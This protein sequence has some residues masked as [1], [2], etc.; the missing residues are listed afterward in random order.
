[1]KII[2]PH[3]KDLSKNNTLKDKHFEIVRAMMCEKLIS[4][5]NN[6]ELTNDLIKEHLHLD[7]D[8]TSFY[9]NEKA[10]DCI[11]VTFKFNLFELF[12]CEFELPIY[13]YYNED[14]QQSHYSAQYK[15][16][17]LD[18]TLINYLNLNHF[19]KDPSQL[20]FHLQK[21]YYGSAYAIKQKNWVVLI[22]LRKFVS[23]TYF[24]DQDHKVFRKTFE[25]KHLGKSSGTS[26]SLNSN[27]DIDAEMMLLRFTKHIMNVKA[28][29]DSSFFDYNNLNFEDNNWFKVVNK[30]FYDNLNGENKVGFMDYLKL[31]EMMEI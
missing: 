2:F 25:I 8:E 31:I 26:Y 23:M 24:F 13:V 30:S 5:N 20:E 14:G 28:D 17:L 15:G 19:N 7:Q 10:N 1:M 11:I 27:G 6:P 3:F 21:D 12:N 22:A 4:I 16:D 18:S 9:V 29:V